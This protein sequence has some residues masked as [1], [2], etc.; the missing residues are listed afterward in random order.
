M[1]IEKGNSNGE[2]IKLK[3][4]EATQEDVGKGIVCID[5]EEK[6]KLRDLS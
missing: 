6:V 1:S 5:P 2:S 3:I 4:A